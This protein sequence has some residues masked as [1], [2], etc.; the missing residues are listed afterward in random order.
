MALFARKR[1]STVITFLP[2]GVR[3]R[4]LKT[5]NAQRLTDVG[6]TSEEDHYEKASQKSVCT[7]ASTSEN[8]RVPDVWFNL[9]TLGSQM[10]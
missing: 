7:L 4:A 10:S 1:R 6:V 2:G 8:G 5:L 3:Y 9:S